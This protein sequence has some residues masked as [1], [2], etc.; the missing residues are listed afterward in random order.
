MASTDDDALSNIWDNESLIGSAPRRTAEADMVMWLRG[1]LEI[2]GYTD[3]E[4]EKLVNLLGRQAA[5]E[6]VLLMITRR[7]K[8]EDA[9]RLGCPWK[10]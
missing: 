5:A 9:K 10:I 1:A 2:L 7:G 3:T 4:Y 6:T 8:A